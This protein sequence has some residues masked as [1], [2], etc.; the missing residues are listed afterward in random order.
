MESNY[1]N[2]K[3]FDYDTHL[4][5]SENAYLKIIELIKIEIDKSQTLLD[6]GTGTGE[7]PIAIADGVMKIIATDFSQEMI[8]IAFKKSKKLKLDNITFKVQDCYAQNYGNEIFDVIIASN[9]LHLL[10]EPE[11]FINSLK[12]LL[13][14]GGKLIIPTYLHNESFKTRFISK[15]LKFKG[16][17]I[18]TKFDSISL[19][20]FITNCGYNVEKR[21]FIKNI[22]PMLFVVATRK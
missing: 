7:I 2:I 18:N 17:P 9:L 21:V 13:N 22:M 15:I 14:K 4:K 6:L 3:A 11:Q 20:E 16:H 19:V 12:R 10:D 8:D 5:K 1:W